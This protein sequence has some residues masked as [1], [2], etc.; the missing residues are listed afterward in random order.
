MN[1]GNPI[2]LTLES[3]F[4]TELDNDYFWVTAHMWHLQ[5]G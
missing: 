3:C 1:I 2:P 5:M 4:D